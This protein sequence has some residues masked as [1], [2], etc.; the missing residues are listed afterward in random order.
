MGLIPKTGNCCFAG[1]ETPRGPLSMQEKVEG[2]TE[3]GA[4]RGESTSRV[5]DC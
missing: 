3:V 2:K 1:R 4:L 5:R